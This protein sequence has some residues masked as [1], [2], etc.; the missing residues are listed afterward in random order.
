MAIGRVVFTKAQGGSGRPLIGKDHISGLIGYVPDGSLPS[1]WSTTARQK[2]LLSVSDAETAGLLLNY[3]DGTGATGTI[4]VTGVGATGDVI[5]T[6]SA[7]VLSNVTVS[8]YTVLAADTT[9]TLLAASIAANINSKTYLHGYSATSA[10]G[11]ITV[12]APKK[13]GI[14][15]NTKSLSIGVTG[16][17]TLTTGSFTGGLSSRTA[18]M[19]YHISEFFRLAPQGVLYVGFYSAP[20]A[21][22]SEVKTLCDFANGDI[23]QIA[24][25]DDQTTYSTATLTIVHNAALT[26]DNAEKPL[27]ILYTANIV[28]FTDVST[29]PDLNALSANKVTAIIG[30]DGANQ[31]F[32]M[33]NATGKT[34]SCIGASLGALSA[35]RV[36][37]S[38]AEVGKFNLSNTL[39]MEVVSFGNGQLLSGLTDNKIDNVD[40]YRYVFAIK[41]TGYAGTFLNNNYTAIASNSPYAYINDNRVIDKAIRLARTGLIP[42]LSSEII[43]NADGTL[44]DITVA[45]FEDAIKDQVGQMLTAQEISGQ[46]VIINPTQNVATTSNLVVS[47]T[48]RENGIARSISVNI[49]F[50]I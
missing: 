15:L 26:C 35:S 24:I 29:L 6:V 21:L 41:R 13:Q 42:L 16:T 5:K 45:I 19:Y 48:I 40:N 36:S 18:Q 27:S 14:F 11:V 28:S 7:E 44:T 39:E 43:F 33:F 20:S 47:M 1:G 10:A 3:S 50:K 37:A 22:Y 17:A 2:K 38:F 34:V 25:F 23:R 46:T 49:G 12:I 9:V 31:G 32:E 30:Q 4:T 8:N